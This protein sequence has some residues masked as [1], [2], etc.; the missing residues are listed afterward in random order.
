[1]EESRVIITEY[2]RNALRTSEYTLEQVLASDF[3][4]QA[5]DLV[6]HVRWI[7][8]EYYRMG[9]FWGSD[10]RFAQWGT[11]PILFE[12]SPILLLQDRLAQLDRKAG[13][14][15]VEEDDIPGK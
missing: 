9:T 8:V 13:R 10:Y 2:S 7:Y 3:I 4:L 5:G 12:K 14:P 15:P 11:D 6:P 1:M